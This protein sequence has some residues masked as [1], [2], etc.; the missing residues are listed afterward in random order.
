M[1]FSVL[2][3]LTVSTAAGEPVAVPESK[4]RALLAD[5]LVHLGQ[6]VTPDRLIDHLWGSAPPARALNT[7]QTKISQVRRVLDAA[8][9]GGRELLVHQPA[10][11]VLQADPQSLDAHRFSVLATQARATSDPRSRAERLTAALSLWRGDALA[12]FRDEAFAQAAI[13]RLE[14]DRLV[15]VEELAETRLELGEHAQLAGELGDLVARHPLRE[16]LR[17]AHIRALYGGGRPSEA[18]ASYHDLREKLAEDLGLD[19]GARLTALQQSILE[20]DPA[21]GP[22]DSLRMRL[23]AADPASQVP[24]PPDV[25]AAQQPYRSNVP[26]PLTELIGREQAIAEVNAL[27]QTHR[28][29]TLTGPGGVGKTRLALAVAAGLAEHSTTSTAET[30][31]SDGI[32]FVELGTV[33]RPAP[34]G[35]HT[36][37]AGVAD[38]IASILGIH[39][40]PGGSTAS[41]AGRPS[42]MDRLAR[43]FH[44]RQVVLVL[45]NCEHLVEPVAD[46]ASQLLATAPHVR[47]LATSREPLGV[48]GELI[49][50]VP[51]LD[52]PAAA[53]TDPD[54]LRAFS[55]TELFVAR[56]A[57]A[58]PGFTL[59]QDNAAQVAAICRRLDGIPL[60]IEL[61]A[62]R[63]PGL[64]AHALAARLDD[65]FRL[66][67]AGKRGVPARQR[68]LRAMIDW[69]WELLSADERAVL[70]RLAVHADGATLEAA[71]SVCA[72]IGVAAGDIAPVL[73]RLV[74]QSLV[75]AT[76]VGEE[77][78]YRLLE[79]VAAY[80]QERL[81]EAGE[82]TSAAARHRQYYVELAERA[83][84]HVRAS[85]QCTWLRRLC[86]ETPNIR[87]AIDTAV[88]DHAIED[89]LRLVNALAWAWC[90]RGRRREAI[91]ALEHVLDAAGP[92][93][94]ASTARARSWHAGLTVLDGGARTEPSDA[95]LKLFDDTH[96]PEGRAHAHWLLGYAEFG[97]GSLS[98]SERLADHALAAFQQLGHRWGVAASLM[99]K[100]SQ[101]IFHGDLPSVV[102]YGEQSAE[103]FAEVG[104]GWGRLQTIEVLGSHAEIIGD[105]QAAQSLFEEGLRIAEYLEMWSEHSGMLTRMGRIA[106]LQGDYQRADRLHEHAAQVA[107]EHSDLPS[108]ER[109]GV[110]LA[111]SARRQ[112]RLATAEEHLRR[113][114]G[115]NHQVEAE[116]GLS[117]I[118]SE[119]GFVAEL[120]RDAE[121][122]RSHHTEALTRARATGDPRAIA[123]ALEGLAGADSLAGHGARA[124][125]LIGSATALRQHVGAPLPPAER[126]DVDRITARIVAALGQPEFDAEFAAGTTLTPD[127]LS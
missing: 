27:L 115:W 58:A 31:A 51:P 15:A 127:Q 26:V 90:L 85:E 106:I 4:V 121:T 60:A 84:P 93:S 71:E 44:G 107:A 54:V 122:A 98:L 83:E 53:A 11:Y 40:E 62:S 47:I 89:A 117:L 110:G 102:H 68:T 124:A 109:A 17:A 123:L 46:L 16:R 75:V 118:Y 119:L 34:D 112:G 9:P 21:L 41:G 94:T 30:V 48:P 92:V 103:I 111:L 33:P 63:I 100:A 28:L 7:L 52:L 61:A 99:L 59:T 76:Q 14:E 24:A 3:P 1:R 12:G 49:Q 20:Q 50:V 80:C 67:S 72:D 10:G 95:V 6:P 101:A 125:Q 77:T 25:P 74:D 39:D 81:A 105:Y 64:G 91:R 43:S 116:Y 32:W 35:T 55:A 88:A 18:L 104:D 57:A 87:L 19:P 96:D 108:E 36:A 65:R 78:R 73:A 56:A 66:L 69:S 70:R 45:D 82:T 97:F 113:W 2:G 37:V 8:A 13:A 42:T 5:L 79:S 86:V 22:P 23:A 126:A 114:L 38:L 120:R 29:V